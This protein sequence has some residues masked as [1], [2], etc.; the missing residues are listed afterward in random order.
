MPTMSR[1]NSSG[2]KGF[3]I[4]Q[5]F[6]GAPL[7]WMP[8]VGT[9]ELDELVHAYVAGSGTV[10]EKRTVISI[11]FFEFSAQTGETFKYYP[12]TAHAAPASP[13]MSS[14]MSYYGSSP[15]Q[16][17]T[18][19]PNNTNNGMTRAASRQPAAANKAQSTTD[20]SQLP[21]MKILTIDGDDV[22][23][24]VSRGCKTKEQ[25]EHA[26][27]MRV[28]KACDACK[29]KKIRCDPSHKRRASAAQGK[30]T[31]EAGTA[32][33]PP[34]AKKVRK[35]KVP[36][37]PASASSQ[38]AVFTSVPDVSFDIDMSA[39]EDVS[40]IDQSWA[41]FLTFDNDVIDNHHVP[42]DFYGAVPQDFDFF[43]DGHDSQFSPAISGSSGS[44]D[45]PAQPLTP[46]NSGMAVPHGGDFTFNDDQTLAF[47]GQ[48]PI[49]PYMHPAGAN[50]GSNYLDFN[51]FSPATSFIDEEPHK[52]K[53]GD[54][55]KASALHAASGPSIGALS[56]QTGGT[57]AG[58]SPSLGSPASAHGLAHSEEWCFDYC[59]SASGSSTDLPRGT[60]CQVPGAQHQQD[61]S[62]ANGGAFASGLMSMIDH[63]RICAHIIGRSSAH[64][65]T[66]A[67][68]TAHDLPRPRQAIS[69]G[70]SPVT[71][72]ALLEEGRETNSQTPGF[73]VRAPASSAP[74]SPP[75]SSQV[76]L[77]PRA[78]VQ[79]DD[80]LP[81]GGSAH[82]EARTVSPTVSRR[83]PFV[84][85]CGSSCPMLTFE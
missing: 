20:F 11:D 35:E 75:P 30:K 48:E 85:V 61:G 73:A 68:A 6:L 54:K 69:S 63:P 42:Q 52:L 7:A 41:E 4:L 70:Y 16:A 83:V 67:Q 57:D 59:G 13:A 58:R 23:N 80:V 26:H 12:V 65:V 76:V 5:P 82:V 81:I 44:F 1:T 40:S 66:T 22:T 10:Q 77:G 62:P 31:T 43:F 33:K 60:D 27:L 28:L 2:L 49:L 15:S 24:S 14:D 50:H 45:S 47:L 25:R 18:P 9:K 37:S 46:V 17:S 72:A 36:P 3:S 51:L 34:A 56:P 79:R 55:R 8:A 29:R 38:S 32:A 64:A 71:A 21:G 84:V 39:F 19:A 78:G 53:A 74:V